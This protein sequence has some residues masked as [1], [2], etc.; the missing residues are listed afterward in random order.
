MS[1][2]WLDL[3]LLRLRREARAEPERAAEILLTSLVPSVTYGW[4]GSSSTLDTP[5]NRA[6]VRAVTEELS[7]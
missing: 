2:N 5:E 4:R 6:R 3:E 1:R 7:A